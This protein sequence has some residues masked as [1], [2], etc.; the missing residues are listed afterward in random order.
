MPSDLKDVKFVGQ[1]P[2]V[3]SPG[4]RRIQAATQLL[5]DGD[6]DAEGVGPNQCGDVTGRVQK[7]RVNTL[8]ILQR[9]IEAETERE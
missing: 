1:H 9:K 5:S 6:R 3:I 8:G 4:L 2:P 7:R